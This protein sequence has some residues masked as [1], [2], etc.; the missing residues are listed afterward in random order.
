MASTSTTELQEFSTI[1]SRADAWFSIDE[2][3]N[4]ARQEFSLPPVDRGKDAWFFL[5]ASFMMEA[6][7]WG[8]P[9]YLNTNSRIN[10]DVLFHN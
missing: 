6:L 8:K 7:T 1:S 5:A 3:S 9:F 4:N 2:S 10:N